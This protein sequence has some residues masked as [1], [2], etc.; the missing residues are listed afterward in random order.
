[1]REV[2]AVQGK[3]E[4]LGTIDRSEQISQTV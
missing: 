4:W 2:T 3:N 1:M